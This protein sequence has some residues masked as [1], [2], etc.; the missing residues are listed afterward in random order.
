MR[1]ATSSQ[2]YSLESWAGSSPSFLNSHH[3]KTLA[4][5]CL[6]EAA[7][8]LQR[9]IVK[10]ADFLFSL[11]FASKTVFSPVT[12]FRRRNSKFLS[13][14]SKSPVSL[15]SYLTQF[16]NEFP[17]PLHNAYFFMVHCSFSGAAGLGHSRLKLLSYQ[18]G[19]DVLPDTWLTFSAVVGK[20]GRVWTG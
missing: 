7:V 12:H 9:Q 19:N 2:N 11:G 8:I 5:F 20:Q 6:L 16:S 1:W 13:R 3:Q 15:V 4:P 18:S 14:E 10:L 17:F